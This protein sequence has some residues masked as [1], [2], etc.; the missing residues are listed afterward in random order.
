MKEINEQA[1]VKVGELLRSGYN[2][3]GEIHRNVDTPKERQGRK[4]SYYIT[5]KLA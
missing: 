4:L 1:K 2:F 3:I 5:Q